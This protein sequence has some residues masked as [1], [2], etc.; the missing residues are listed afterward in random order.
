MVRCKCSHARTQ[1]SHGAGQCWSRS[2]G[3]TAYRPEEKPAPEERCSFS[4]L[5]VSGCAHCRGNQ[6][7]VA[8]DLLTP[9][10]VGPRFTARYDGECGACAGPFEEGD[11][12]AALLVMGGY[13]CPGCLP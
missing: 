7:P 1:H 8:G 2:C 5:P 3:C 12:I 4:D 11:T 13:A 9:A 10:D 6:A